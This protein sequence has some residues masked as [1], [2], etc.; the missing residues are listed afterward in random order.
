MRRRLLYLDCRCPDLL[1]LRAAAK[2]PEGPAEAR[3]G[4]AANFAK[5]PDL[6]RRDRPY[7]AGLRGINARR[8]S[9]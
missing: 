1:V 9:W 4:V 6:P 7:P 3:A 5:L 8:K 2:A